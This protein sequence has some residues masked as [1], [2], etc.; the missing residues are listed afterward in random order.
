M[1]NKYKKISY[2][3]LYKQIGLNLP[4]GTFARLS[5]LMFVATG[6]LSNIDRLAPISKL[7]LELL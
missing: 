7:E 2:F 6:L 5:A 1:K 4:F 3:S